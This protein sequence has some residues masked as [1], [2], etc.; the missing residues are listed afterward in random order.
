MN[1]YILYH[2]D[3]DTIVPSN[4]HRVKDLL[5]ITCDQNDDDDDDDDDDDYEYNIAGLWD[6]VS[7]NDD[8]DTRHV[9]LTQSTDSDTNSNDQHDY[10]KN[11]SLFLPP[12]YLMN[13]ILAGLYEIPP[14]HILQYQTGWGRRIRYNYTQNIP[15]QFHPIPNMTNNNDKEKGEEDYTIQYMTVQRYSH[16][17]YETMNDH[18]DSNNQQQHQ[19]R[20]RATQCHELAIYRIQFHDNN[21]AMLNEQLYKFALEHEQHNRIGL[22][23]SNAGGTYHGLPNFFMNLPKKDTTTSKSKDF[24]MTT[25]TQGSMNADTSTAINQNHL[26]EEHDDTTTSSNNNEC[27]YELYQR[28][29]TVTDR[30]EQHQIFQQQQ[31]QYR[32]EKHVIKDNGNDNNISSSSSST[33]T[34]SLLS[35]ESDTIK[36]WVNI[37]H[38]N[39]S[40]NRLHTHEGSAWSGVYYVSSTSQSK[41]LWNGNIVFK[42]TPHPLEDTTYT[43]TS[44]ETNRLRQCHLKYNGSHDSYT[45]TNK[46]TDEVQYIMIPRIPGEMIIFPSYIHHCVLPTNSCRVVNDDTKTNT[47]VVN[48]D[49]DDHN[50]NTLRISIAFNINWK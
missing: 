32:P 34:S 6:H 14:N 13:A 25:N 43:L 47:N 21:T 4:D 18:F 46:F 11:Q 44:I 16:Y 2:N 36:G 37:S 38:G 20:K 24:V 30:I 15:L 49:N 27:R 50:N 48:D 12:A 22:N 39:G 1:D 8:Y 19:Q 5:R 41:T 9:S 7:D 35:L 26:N 28:I 10:D 3:N 29:C 45:N 23:V 17:E 33:S 42:P 31:Q 40:W